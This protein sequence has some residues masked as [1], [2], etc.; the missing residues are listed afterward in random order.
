MDSA[1]FRRHRRPAPT[2]CV[3]PHGPKSM[4]SL[5]TFPPVGGRCI[6]QTRHLAVPS[7]AR[8][9]SQTPWRRVPRRFGGAASP[10]RLGALGRREKIG[11]LRTTLIFALQGP[12]HSPNARARMI[13]VRSNLG[14]DPEKGPAQVRWCGKPAPTRGARSTWLQIL[15]G[16]PPSL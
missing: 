6:A 4:N 1:L 12:P 11:K 2:L 14:R 16:R 5:S 9:S 10:H 13:R 3:G 7:A 15:V 8:G